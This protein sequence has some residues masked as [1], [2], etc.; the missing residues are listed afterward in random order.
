[1]SVE[2]IKELF[3]KR[4]SD[5][6]N[7]KCG[8]TLLQTDANEYKNDEKLEKNLFDSLSEREAGITEYFNKCEGFSAVIKERYSDFQVNEIDLDGNL[9]RLTNFDIPVIKETTFET[10]DNILDEAVW[11]QLED[12]KGGKVSSVEIDVTNLNKSQRRAI[13]GVIKRKYEKLFTTNT[14]SK[15]GEEDKKIMVISLSKNTRDDW[16]NECGDYLHFVLFKTNIDT[17]QAINI[18]ASK[19]SIKASNF[20]YAGTKDKRG[21]TSQQV[22]MWHLKPERLISLNK[23]L[24]NIKLGNFSYNDR[25]IKLG[26]L[27]GNHFKIALRNVT[28]DNEKVDRALHSLKE[29]GFINYFGLQRFGCSPEVPTFQIG[30][31]L[32]KGDFKSAVELILKPKEGKIGKDQLE[33]AKRIWWETRD[34]KKASSVLKFKS[35]THEGRLLFGLKEHGANNYVNALEEMP[36]NVRLLYLHSYQSLLWNKIVSKR[37]KEFGSKILEGDL[38][39]VKKMETDDD[40]KTN[41]ASKVDNFQ[42]KGLVRHIT[43]DELS[44]YDITDVVHPMPGYNISYPNNII[45]TWYEELLKEEDLADGAFKQR[46]KE[47]SISG[48]YR[49][50]VKKV[51]DLTWDIVFYSKPEDDL[52]LSDLDVIGNDTSSY[53][54]K[55]NGQY[56]AVILDFTLDSSTYATMAL[57]EVLKIN[58]SSSYQASLNSYSMK[59]KVNDGNEIGDNKKQ[60]C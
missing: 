52:I 47:Y 41:D 40:T 5:A 2:K 6:E 48:S 25:P 7:L 46:V 31:S 3:S 24:K 12:L 43:A 51:K 10:V 57:R 18:I 26:D 54:V 50:I 53:G 11:L 22:S 45:K 30:K 32:L 49:N 14:V 59:R 38:I 20:T 29:N 36:R 19:L 16:H 42:E 8:I 44:N 21:K 35:K 15:D 23:G 13:H 60:K 37:I 55:E 17:L 58:I 56:K 4:T 1:M 34:A 9:V 28:V 33:V 27:K 39:F